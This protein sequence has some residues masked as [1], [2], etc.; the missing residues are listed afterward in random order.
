MPK[1]T[2][3]ELYIR[4]LVSRISKLTSLPPGAVRAVIDG[5]ELCIL[6]DIRKQGMAHDPDEKNEL[7]IELPHFGTLKMST[8]KYP[9][10]MSKILDGR[11]FK[12]KIT[13][14]ETFLNRVRW[15]YYDKYDY[16]TRQITTGFKGLIANHFKS[17]IEE[18]GED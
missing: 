5:V 12:S 15:A 6:D 3:N 13:I 18:D 7:E 4:S 16:L 14:S 11:S 10:S 2:P 17:I 9:A 1:L 8:T